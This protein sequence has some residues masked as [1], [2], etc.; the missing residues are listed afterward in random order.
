MRHPSVVHLWVALL[1]MICLSGFAFA[2]TGLPAGVIDFAH[3]N[4]ALEIAR[5]GLDGTA[6]SLRMPQIQR[7]DSVMDFRHY[8]VFAIPGEPLYERDGCPAVPHI[9]RLYRVPNTGTVELATANAEWELLSDINTLPIQWK[10]E[11][12]TALYYDRS[13]Y[14]TDAWY[15][16]E[17]VVIGPPKIF[18]DFRVVQVTFFPVQINPVTRQARVWRNLDVNLIAHP[19][20]PGENELLQTRQPS[21]AFVPLYR[22]LI[23]NLDENALDDATETPGTYLILC[24][25][26]EIALQWADSLATWRRRCGFD[27]VI[28][29]RSS[30]NTSSIR[31][32]IYAMYNSAD[33]PLEFVCII[34]D[35]Q[36][37]LLGMPTHSW[38]YDHYYA[39]L[40]GD[41]LEEV[42]L[43]RFPASSATDLNLIF[44]KIAAYERDPYMDDPSWFSRAFLYAG[45]GYGISSNHITMLWARQQFYRFTGVNTVNIA[46][47]GSGSINTSLVQQRINEGVSYFLWRGTVVGEMTNSVAYGTNNGHRLPVCLTITCGTGDFESGTSTSESW[48][49]AGTPSNLK[50]GVCGIGTATTGT[51][52]HFNNTVAGGLVYNICN[53]GVQY[54]GMAFTGAKAQLYAAYPSDYQAQNFMRWNNLMGDPAISLWTRQPTVMNVTYAGTVNVGTRRIRPQVLDNQTGQPISDALV[55]LW[56]GEEVYE[57]VLSDEFGFADVPVHVNS[58]GIMTLS[59]T[60]QNHKPFLGNINCVPSAEMVT[61]SSFTLD[62]D[63]HNGTSGNGN[64]IVNPGETIDMAC[65]VRNFGASQ[66][67]SGITATITS[68]NPHLTIV[69]GNIS[70]ADI[71]AG[72]SAAGASPFRFT[73]SSG[74]KHG[75]KALLTIAVNTSSQITHSSQI[76]TCAAGHAIYISHQVSG[77]DGD[78][79]LEPGESANLRV[80][81]ENA[82]DIALQNLTGVLQARTSF[83]HVN[84]PSLDYG[85]IQP[86]GLGNGGGIG[87]SV[88][89]NSLAYPGFPAELILILT[90]DSGYSDSIS[91]VIPLGD[92]AASDPTGPDAYGYFAYDNTDLDYEH[93]RDF[94]WVDVRS[95]GANLNLN[96]PGEQT[97]GAPTYSITRNLPFPFRLYGDEYTQ[98]TVCS[99]G[100]AAFG[101]QHELDGF[102][103]YPIPGQQ[104]PDALIAAFWDDLRTSGS[105]LGVWDYYDATNHRYVIQWQA[106]GFGSYYNTVENFEIILIDPAYEM[107]R[108]SNGVVI[109]QY[110]Q[111]S[112]MVAQ[113]NDTPYSTVGIQAPG[114]LV[115]LQY[116]FNNTAAP[117]GANLIAGRSIVFTTDSRTAFGNIM[118]T[119]TDAATSLPM[120]NVDVVVSGYL[121]QDTMRT[122]AQG[123]FSFYNVGIGE[124]TV[125]AHRF[126]YN[127]G[128]IEDVIVRQ[129][130]TATVV[131]S[132]LHPEISVSVDHVSVMLPQDPNESYFQISNNGNGPLDYDISIRFSTAANLDDSWNY[133][134]GVNATTATGNW[135]IQGCEMVGDYWWVTGSGEQNTIYRFDL[136]GSLAGSF[137]Q[138]PGNGYGWCD[139]AYDG[140][141]VYGSGGAA[142][143]GMNEAG[144][145]VDTIPSPLDPTRALAYDPHTDHF[146]VADY[147]SDILEI[148]RNGEVI[149]RFPS[150]Y[151]VTGLAWYPNEFNGY[152]LY[153]FGHDTLS[154]HSIVSR[155]HPISGQQEYVRDLGIESGDRAGGCTITAGWNSTLLVFGGILQN[156]SGD[157]LGIWELNFNTTWIAVTPMFGS[158][159]A[160]T[161]REI[162]IAFDPS[163]LRDAVYHVDLTISNNSASGSITLPVSLTVALDAGQN[164]WTPLEYRLYQNYPNP[165]NGTTTIQY[166]L[167]RQ[168][169]V[170]LQVYN[171]LGQEVMTPMHEVQAA[172]THRIQ[173]DVGDLPSGLYLYRIHSG[174]FRETRKLMLLK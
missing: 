160:G 15:P 9:T 36:S 114:S 94:N 62:D 75:E 159:P 169:L 93:S 126:G 83:V 51:H 113:G 158:I 68:N 37:S 108:D 71:T 110:Q 4:Q 79:L 88:S 6:I 148:D 28:D 38:D 105:G 58:P 163:T 55:V 97:P 123:R 87:F 135:L 143:I 8:D 77:G 26:A 141:T 92:R 63:N 112:E 136:N 5:S 11:S 115:G 165:F 89:G 39:D 166:D 49:L 130:S 29:A 48:L 7:I 154:Q 16:A 54:L 98:I 3:E 109:V 162:E 150:R 18:R 61:L 31:S 129:D 59:V 81:V 42:A 73:V 133:L 60:K 152:R 124:Y 22:N 174:D 157:R 35:P 156:P 128:V 65:Y 140:Q 100:W 52:V 53:L 86:G 122:D 118:G 134:T 101:D 24:R 57:R 127:D 161:N 21:R 47:H 90:T 116:R 125:C 80:T 44:N 85:T 147:A 56:K 46:T 30:W 84:T 107:S 138:P 32:A 170:E 13:I 132:M 12:R 82:G 70:F 111:V 19:E 102:R 146:W 67:A 139:M 17:P 43:G 172:G 131:F 168:G 69:N 99:N 34:G 120:S 142:I 173:L 149:Q 72:D 40:T 96:D 20:A 25:D 10:D 119:V 27:V 76:L 164:H 66:T 104:A 23:A 14:D 50:G 106:A 2:E 45:E 103:N 41:D 91:F 151:R 1:L 78:F 33:P 144:V 153:I 74:M 145:V 64:G 121:V 95:V 117:G 167:K 155:M 171:V 137:P